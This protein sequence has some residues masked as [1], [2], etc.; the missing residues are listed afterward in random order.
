MTTAVSITREYH[1][2]IR[3]ELAELVELHQAAFPEVE[4]FGDIDDLEGE[5]LVF[6]AWDPQRRPIGYIA[7]GAEMPSRASVLA[8]VTCVARARASRAAERSGASGSTTR[9][10]R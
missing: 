5:P 4:G 2:A 7:S 9:A 10:S 8:R 1:D 6:V 3:A